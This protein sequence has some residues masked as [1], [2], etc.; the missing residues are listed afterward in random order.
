L[1]PG[2]SPS[3]WKALTVFTMADEVIH[4]LGKR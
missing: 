4:C 2:E 3:A 1:C